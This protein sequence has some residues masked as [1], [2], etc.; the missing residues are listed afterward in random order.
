M[1]S[2]KSSVAIVR[3]GSN[4]HFNGG[5]GMQLI[6]HSELNVLALFPDTSLGKLEASF[7]RLTGSEGTYRARC[8]CEASALH[9]P[10]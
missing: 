7:R 4:S 5:S 10:I 6:I 3:T 9:I 2:R 8:S 1:K